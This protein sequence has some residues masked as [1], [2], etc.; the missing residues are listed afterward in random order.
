MNRKDKKFL[1]KKAIAE[2]KKGNPNST[3]DEFKGFATGFNMC[4]DIIF[5]KYKYWKEKNK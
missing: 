4:F 5:K 2:F 1:R 3:K